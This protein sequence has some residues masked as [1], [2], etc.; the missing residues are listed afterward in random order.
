[1]LKLAR[2]PG[3][4]VLLVVG[5]HLELEVAL[6]GRHEI[7]VFAPEQRSALRQLTDAQRGVALRGDVPVVGH[8]E[9]E[10]ALVGT[11]HQRRQEPA[12]APA[13]QGKVEVGRVEDRQA[14]EAERRVARDAQVL[15]AVQRDLAGPDHPVF[16]ARVAG[17]VAARV[18]DRETGA[19]HGGGP[20]VAVT[21]GG[22]EPIVHVLEPGVL[23]GQVQ[24]ALGGL[25][26][27]LAAPEAH[28]V[29]GLD[30]VG[31]PV[32]GHRVC[33]HGLVTALEDHPPEDVGGAGPAEL[34]LVGNDARRRLGGGGGG[35][36]GD[37][38]LRGAAERPL[39]GRR[40]QRAAG[41]QQRGR[42]RHPEGVREAARPGQRVAPIA[43][44]RARL[45]A[46]SAATS[47]GFRFASASGQPW[48]WRVTR[49]A[50]AAMWSGRSFRAGT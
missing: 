7:T 8:Y 41:H 49:S 31:L 10:A 25:G 28:A 48:A 3:A 13:A 9:L 19:G 44:A 12:L 4:S 32:I 29:Q 40:G 30:P 26:V 24:L 6:A 1:M 35:R 33:G 42:G 23:R 16:R 20:R 39:P 34:G 45:A 50:S 38:G 17:R 27:H 37:P 21:H 2:A 14:L 5:D 43:S 18:D 15:G 46:S 22:E 47:A 36:D 11:A